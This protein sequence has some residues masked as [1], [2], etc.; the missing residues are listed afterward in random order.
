MFGTAINP[1]MSVKH[2]S[3]TSSQTGFSVSII[4]VVHLSC[5]EVAPTHRE[6]V[7][8]CHSVRDG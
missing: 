3:L 8:V 5:P 6:Y 4:S 1:R 2:L 7:R